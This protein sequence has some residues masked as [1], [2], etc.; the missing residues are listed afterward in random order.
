LRGMKAR[1][2][3]EGASRFCFWQ[4]RVEGRGS[5]EKEISIRSAECGMRNG[6]GNV[7]RN[8]LNKLNELREFGDG[9][10]P[11]LHWIKAIAHSAHLTHSAHS[12]HS[13]PSTHSAHSTPLT[14]S[15]PSTL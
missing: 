8:R 14:H 10:R 7:I 1:R 13:T 3:F 9:R 12:A 6:I 2:F 4:Q 11:P 5:R 15:T